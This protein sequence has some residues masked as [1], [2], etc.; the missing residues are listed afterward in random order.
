MAHFEDLRKTAY[1]AE[2]DLNTYQAKQGLGKKSDST[3]ES[4][5]DEMVNQ[6]FSEPTGVKYGPG[7]TASGSDHRKI[8][9][10]EGGTRD[11]RDRLPKAEHFQGDD[12]PETG[13]KQYS[14]NRPGDQEALDPQDLK[15]RGLA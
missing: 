13:V 1:K 14:E 4:G 3:L 7:S 12:G 9:E 8:P 6:R 15:R 10:D 5:V 2:N 11:D